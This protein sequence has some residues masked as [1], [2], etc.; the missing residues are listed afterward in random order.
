MT[1]SYKRSSSNYSPS[2]N[3]RC[4][5]SKVNYVETKALDS[6][7]DNLKFLGD[8]MQDMTLFHSNVSLMVCVGTNG[9]V[10]LPCFDDIDDTFSCKQFLVPQNS[11]QE[12]S[13][14]KNN[15]DHLAILI[16][17]R[18]KMDCMTRLSSLLKQKKLNPI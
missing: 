5:L 9:L 8:T 15:Y 1:S 6:H 18:L 16:T 12:H 10:E 4:K 2:S 13:T 11:E 17:S 7:L 14:C 3:T